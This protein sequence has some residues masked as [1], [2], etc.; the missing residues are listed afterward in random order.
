M[1]YTCSAEKYLGRVVADGAKQ[2]ACTHKNDSSS[3]AQIIGADVGAKRAARE[4][5]A[6]V[7]CVMSLFEQIEES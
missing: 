5:V 4:A 7:V 6:P 1:G 2:G 3:R